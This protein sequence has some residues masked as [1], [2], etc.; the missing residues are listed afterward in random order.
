LL[1]DRNNG[2]LIPLSRPKELRGRVIFH[3]SSY[4]FTL[5]I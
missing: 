3:V 5:I 4:N 1:F 2:V